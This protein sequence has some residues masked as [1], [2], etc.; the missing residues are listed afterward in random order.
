MKRNKINLATACYIVI[1]MILCA[2]VGNALA[3]YFQ[4]YSKIDIVQAQE[5][6]FTS[7]ILDGQEHY[8]S[9]GADSMSFSVGNHEDD[10]RYSDMDITYTVSVQPLTGTDIMPEIV[11]DPAG[12]TLIGGDIRDHTV[13]VR[14]LQPGAEYEVIVTGDGGYKKTLSGRFTVPPRENELYKYLK[15]YGTYVLLTVWSQGYEG[16]VTIAYQKNAIPD[17]TDPVMEI[18]VTNGTITDTDSFRGSPYASHPYAS[19]T[20]RFFV[21]DAKLSVNDFT[22]TYDNTRTAEYKKP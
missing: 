8:L 20:Y 17:N 12:T 13:T 5:F 4:S 14:N 9:P 1:G 3:K 15:D 10:L 19:H 2:L 22:V 7:P 18:A 11:T 16:D 6:Y 21:T